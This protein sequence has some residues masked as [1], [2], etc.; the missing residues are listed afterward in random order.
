[1]RRA[2]RTERALSRVKIPA[3]NPCCDA[4]AWATTSSSSVNLNTLNTGPNN[5]VSTIVMSWRGHSMMVGS[6]NNPSQPVTRW[7]PV[8]MLPPSDFAKATCD[9]IC[10][11]CAGVQSGPIWVDSSCGSPIFIDLAISTIRCKNSSAILS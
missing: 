5:S 4:L 11:I 7:P 8:R 6:K 10:V 3:A 9:S 2:I 1:M